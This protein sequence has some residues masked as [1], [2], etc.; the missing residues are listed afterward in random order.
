MNWKIITLLFFLESLASLA[1]STVV[2]PEMLYGKN[3][4]KAASIIIQW[5][6]EHG[7]IT[8]SP[9]SLT[10]RLSKTSYRLSTYAI[11]AFLSKGYKYSPDDPSGRLFTQ[12]LRKNYLDLIETFGDFMDRLDAC[13]ESESSLLKENGGNEKELAILRKENASLR[14]QVR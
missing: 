2:T 10:A 1:Q 7:Y 8:G 5:K 13:S 12:Q 6:K 9:K 14:Y 3:N 11:G 4:A